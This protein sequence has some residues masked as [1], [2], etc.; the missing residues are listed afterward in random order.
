[1]AKL[2][3]MYLT[4]RLTTVEDDGMVIELRAIMREVIDSLNANVEAEGLVT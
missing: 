2:R 3:G 4:R 1:M